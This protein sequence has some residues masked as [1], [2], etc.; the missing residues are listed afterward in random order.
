MQ[1]H[2]YMSH[3]AKNQ[4]VSTHT[5]FRNT[6]IE[7][8]LHLDIIKI[9]ACTLLRPLAKY[10]VFVEQMQGVLKKSTGFP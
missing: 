3:K 9:V 8:Y 2:R 6:E 1:L 10:N 4:N 7:I 5:Q